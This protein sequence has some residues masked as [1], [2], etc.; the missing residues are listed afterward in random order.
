MAAG[1]RDRPSCRDDARTFRDTF[2]NGVAQGNHLFAA[3]IAHGGEARA[4]GHAGVVRRQQRSVLGIELKALEVNLR[5]ETELQMDMKIHE[6]RQHR[7]L[8]Q[9]EDRV[10]RA[11]RHVARFHGGDPVADDDDGHLLADLAGAHV[12][13]STTM[14]QG[15][16]GRWQADGKQHGHDEQE[17]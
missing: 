6:S 14:Q 12:D 8:L 13:Q 5:T 3:E 4:Q 7:A 9:I 16:L 17:P 1:H 10:R 2:R 11:R 15:A